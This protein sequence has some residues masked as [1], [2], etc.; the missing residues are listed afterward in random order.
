MNNDDLIHKWEI[1]K[2]K[3]D[4]LCMGIRPNEVAE[5]IYKRQNPCHDWKTG[6]VGIHIS[7]EGGSHVLVTISHSFDQKSPYS[8][9]FREGNLD[10]LKDG[11]VVSEVIEVPMPNWYSKKTITGA[12]M[13]TFFL[14]EGKAFLHQAYA[15]CDLHS[16][17]MQCKFCGTGSHWKIGEPIEIGKT[18][19]EA[20]MEN[21][22]YH[23]CLGGGTRLPLDHNVEYFSKCASEI[24]KRNSKV[25]IWIEMVPPEYNE[26]ISKLVE[27]GATSFGFNIEIWTEKLREEICPGKFK[28]PKNRYLE[29]ME[30]A[31]SIL[32]PNRVGT[33]L[34]VGLEPIES[35]VEGATALS[36]IGSQPCILPFKPWDKSLYR[37]LP[38]C[39]PEDLISVSET[40]VRAIIENNILPEENQGCLLC[41]GCTIDHDIYKLKIYE[42][43]GSKNENSSS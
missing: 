25:P 24:R 4:L 5:M 36:S 1:I 13:P 29:A 8:I 27:F 16:S 3:A 6:N 15:G 38:P 20:V 40:A 35:S 21:P 41:E 17:G 43:G 42:K 32:G 11:T 30:E 26:G 7:L 28:M 39:N 22:N 10:L 19:A 9:E 14:H 33:C 37:N 12:L 34:L 23:V 2:I 31:L 18:V